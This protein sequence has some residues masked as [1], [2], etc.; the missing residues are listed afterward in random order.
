MLA[1]WSFAGCDAGR[2]AGL[3][4]F[5]EFF[6]ALF[7]P[8]LA[9]PLSGPTCLWRG[10]RCLFDR[11]WRSL[12]LAPPAINA[13]L[14]A[15]GGVEAAGRVATAVR[16]LQG[17]PPGWLDWLAF[18]VWPLF[19][20][21]LLLVFVYAFA[22]LANLIGAPFIAV[23]A[24]CVAGNATPPAGGWLREVGQ[25]M[26][27]ELCKLR[28]FLRRA[29]PLGLLRWVPGVN[30]LAAGLS[31][32]GGVAAGARIS[33][34]PLA[35]CG[36]DFRAVRR[37]AAAMP[38]RVL[39]FGASAL[40]GAVPVVN[41]LP[42]PAA[43]DRC[44]FAGARQRRGLRRARQGMAGAGF[45][46]LS[47]HEVQRPGYQV[48]RGALAPTVR[49]WEWLQPRIFKRPDRR[50]AM[51]FAAEGAP[52]WRAAVFYGTVLPSRLRR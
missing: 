1:G 31:A 21:G 35:N 5:D 18:L 37:T 4:P 48:A 10:F 11:R 9:L 3:S 12:V 7:I 28:C 34:Y 47:N 13:L 45:R 51:A 46:A 22:A 27:S 52:T 25:A 33:G 43:V 29:V 49:S 42:M 32:A 41:L 44:L 36:I 15:G 38:L 14:F 20:A 8:V 30:L 23:L 40:L 17:A 39:G 19:G 50:V 6:Q 26:R 2:A 16:R 24:R